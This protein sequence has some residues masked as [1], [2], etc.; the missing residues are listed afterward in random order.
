MNPK[1]R[2]KEKT[3]PSFH[4]LIIYKKNKT[5]KKKIVENL[6]KK[7]LNLPVVNHVVCQDDVQYL[8]ILA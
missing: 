3:Y 4:S 5:N 6:F 1:N 2:S 8:V 7:T